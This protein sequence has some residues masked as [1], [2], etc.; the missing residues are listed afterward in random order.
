MTR[1]HKH[2]WRGGDPEHPPTEVTCCICGLKRFICDAWNQEHYC[3]LTPRH[4]GPHQCGSI[5]GDQENECTF[6]WQ[7]NK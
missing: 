3:V 6:T 2:R 4:S 7:Q 1:E 5:Y